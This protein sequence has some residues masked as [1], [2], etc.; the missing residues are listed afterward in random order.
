MKIV[1]QR[2]KSTRVVRSN[3]AEGQP[4]TISEIGKG[5][6]IYVGVEKDEPASS[7]DW[8][9]KKL[10]ANLKEDEELLV[11][12]QFTLMAQFKGAKPS[13]HLAEEHSKAASYFRAVVE[14]S[15]A[16]FPGRVKSGIFGAR[17]EIQQ[18]LDEANAELWEC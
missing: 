15:Q 16:E 8:L 6:V 4:S 1:A 18:E 10:Q 5:L 13:F 3:G 9:S 17:L 14:R 2:V 11:L 7:A 12:S